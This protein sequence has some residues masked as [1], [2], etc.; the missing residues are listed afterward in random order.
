MTHVPKSMTK[1]CVLFALQ[2]HRVREPRRK[3][4]AFHPAR[5]SLVGSL[6]SYS[7]EDGGAWF[8]I[9]QGLYA[10]LNTMRGWLNVLSY[11]A[12][13]PDSICSTGGSNYL[14]R[15]SGG[16]PRRRPRV[17]RN[18]HRLT[19]RVAI[20][21]CSNNEP[22]V[23]SIGGEETGMLNTQRLNGRFGP[24][25]IIDCSETKTSSPLNRP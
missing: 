22:G 3:A 18:W 4:P 11:C 17:I 6:R 21:G 7:N 9:I 16:R 20:F 2:C 19:W 1:P 13:S 23:G 14:F 24:R 25:S 12:C 8:D 15:R 10:M 5:C